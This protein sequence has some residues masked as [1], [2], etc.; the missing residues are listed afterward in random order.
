MFT[1]T[2]RQVI[3]DA[4]MDLGVRGVGM[5]LS[6]DEEQDAY[7]RL[8]SIIDT[9]GVQPGT[10][11]TV[12]RTAGV[13]GANVQTFTIGVAGDFNVPRPAFEDFRGAAYIIPG[14]VPDCEATI[15]V[16]G[17]QYWQ[18]LPNKTLTSTLP[19]GIYYNP[20]APASTGLGTL[21]PWPIPTQDVT[22][23]IYLQ[24][25]VQQF[26]SLTA[27][28]ILPPGLYE[29]LRMAMTVKCAPGFGVGLQPGVKE[30][31]DQAMREYKRS[32]TA[33][34]TMVAGWPPFSGQ[35]DINS[36]QVIY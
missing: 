2:G 5:T 34:R 1:T 6:D 9:M 30:Q 32:N 13:L 4:L 11:F 21:Q 12:T 36:G 28:T 7:R 35:Y 22:L 33:M 20:T 14:S 16:F 15:S 29:V 27:S 23:V 24:T 26:A 17:E 8:Q 19:S 10:M 3:A 18:G 31:S 25:A